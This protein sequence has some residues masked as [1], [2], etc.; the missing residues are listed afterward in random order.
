MDVDS[1]E[2]ELETIAGFPENG[3][4]LRRDVAKLLEKTEPATIIVDTFIKRLEQKYQISF[5][6]SSKISIHDSIMRFPKKLKDKKKQ[7]GYKHESVEEFLNGLFVVKLGAKR[8]QQEH[9][10]AIDPK[11]A[12]VASRNLKPYEVGKKRKRYEKVGTS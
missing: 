4:C 5:G 7:L 10:E 9:P 6:A 11:S 8:D 2:E 12:A 1:E 3:I